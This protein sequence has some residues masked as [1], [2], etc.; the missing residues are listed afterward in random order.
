[1]LAKV[2]EMHA[3]RMACPEELAQS[4]IEEEQEQEIE[5]PKIQIEEHKT[6]LKAIQNIEELKTIWASLP[7]E[8]KKELEELKNELKAK[9]ENKSV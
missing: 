2:A 8:A 7:A 1:M 9:Y 5:K 6:K 4:Y 3:L